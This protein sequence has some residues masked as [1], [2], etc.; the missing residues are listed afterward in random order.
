AWTPH[1]PDGRY[2]LRLRG[3]DQAGNT[4]D[5]VHLVDV[6]GTP[7]LA[8]IA[9]PAGGGSVRASFEI[10]GS[11]TDAHFANY[12]VSVIPA[13]QLTTGQWSDIY[14]GTMPVD[15]AKLAA[16]T[17]ALADDSY[18]LRLTVTDKVGLSASD[19]V[20]VRL[21]TQPP[22]IPLNLIGHV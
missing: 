1:L 20:T 6:D 22:P 4:T 3:V 21:D 5:V 2:R 9:A 11:A 10:D 19:Q 7:P 17:L 18:V 8:H 14:V 12:R 15:N 13:A 16:L